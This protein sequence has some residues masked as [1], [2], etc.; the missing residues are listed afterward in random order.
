MT[1]SWK[2]A[3]K[4]TDGKGK[5]VTI[6]SAPR[7]GTNPDLSKVGLSFGVVKALF[8]GDPPHWSSDGH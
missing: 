5:Q 4:L 3:L 7:D 2:G 1:I 8:S 6:D